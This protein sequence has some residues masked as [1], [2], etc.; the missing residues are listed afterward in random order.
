MAG[1]HTSVAQPHRACPKRPARVRSVGN[2]EGVID[3]AVH[4]Y[5][6]KISPEYRPLFD[7]VHGLII[8]SHPDVTVVI[9]YQV[10]TYKVDDRRL[11]LGVWQHGI[12]LYGWGKDRNDDFASR[13]PDLVTGK[14]TIQLRPDDAADIDD[15]ELLGLIRGALSA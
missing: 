6:D 8:D 2:D 14:G 3:P 1:H 7:R 11:Y 13:H 10:P 5:I 12:S 4:D 9:S 15:E